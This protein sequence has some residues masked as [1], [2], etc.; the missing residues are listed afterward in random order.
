MTEDEKT[1]TVDR[2]SK[3]G[4]EATVRIAKADLVPTDA[5]L[6]PDYHSS[7]ELDAACIAFMD[8]V[9][10]PVHRETMRIPSHDLLVKRWRMQPL[11]VA[12]FTTALGQTRMVNSDQTIRFG[13]VRYTAPPELAGPEVRARVEGDDLV[14]TARIDSGLSEVA[15]HRLSTPGNPRSTTRTTSTMRRTPPGRRSRRRSRP[16]TM[17]R[18]RS[19]PLAPRAR[20]AGG[21]HRD[22]RATRPV[23]NGRGRRTRGPGRVRQRR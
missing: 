22:R 10:S 9:N 17:R 23:E 20:V 1:V 7:A 11:P 13:S 3:G 2:E 5:N 16:A 15:R 21:G 19:S 8:D 18:P 6:L 4:S 12:T 14:I